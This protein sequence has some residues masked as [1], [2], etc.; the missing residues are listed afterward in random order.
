M[1]ESSRTPT[2][3]TSPLLVLCTGSFP[4]PPTLPAKYRNLVALDLDLALN[5]SELSK[6]LPMNVQQTVAVIG[7]SHSAILVLRNLYN[8]ATTSHPSLKVFWFSRHS[9]RYAVDKGDWILRD[10]TGLK[11]LVA[12]WARTN[13]D[14]DD[15][16]FAR[17]DVGRVIKKI[18]TIDDETGR[19][20]GFLRS[21]DYVVEATGFT[22]DTLP[23]LFEVEDDGK[24]VPR[25]DKLSYDPVTGAFLEDQSRRPIK[26]LYGAGIAFPEKVVDPEGNTEMAVGMWKFMRYLKRVVPTWIEHTGRLE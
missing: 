13:L 18:S 12:N 2:I 16:A 22:R 19:Y 24:R 20:N 10:N 8:L 1:E 14:Q 17:S 26:G 21:C 6:S 5:P 11:G 7:A 23:N 15:E 4:N 25:R 3:N 9:L